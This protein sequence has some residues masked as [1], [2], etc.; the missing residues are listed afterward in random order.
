M[1]RAAAAPAR[2]APGRRQAPRPRPRP[3]PARK[4]ARRT[5]GPARTRRAARPRGARILHALL[6][7]RGWIAIVG[8]LLAGIVFFNVDLLQMNRDIT[9]MV[10]RAARLKREN[11]RLRLDVARLA[12]SERIQETASG[13]GLV[14]PAPGQVRYLASHPMLDARNASKRMS[15]PDPTYVAPEPAVTI[16]EPPATTVIDPATGLPTDPTGA[17]PPAPATPPTT[18]D[19]TTTTT[20]PTATPPTTTPTTPPESAPATG[21]VE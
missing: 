16:P 1:A 8:V 14:L 2:T 21:A 9:L 7:G 17:T 10:D 12:S 3:A 20:P 4:P 15:A 5:S 11:A 13:L 6:S 19:Q 18:T